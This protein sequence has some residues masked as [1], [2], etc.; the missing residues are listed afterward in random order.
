[1]T[2]KKHVRPLLL[3]LSIR[4]LGKRDLDLVAGKVA[5]AN[6]LKTAFFVS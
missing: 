6:R 2:I 1:V 3:E 4:A 5:V